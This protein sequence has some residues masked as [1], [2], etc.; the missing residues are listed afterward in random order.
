MD[1]NA[2]RRDRQ[3][4]F[5]TARHTQVRTE[6]SPALQDSPFDTPGRTESG[7]TSRQAAQ[8]RDE[9]H[10]IQLI[11]DQRVTRAAH[12]RQPLPAGRTERRDQHATL[13][14]LIE[15][16][17]RDGFPGRGQH[18]RIERRLARPAD[19][20]VVVARADVP[21]LHVAEAPTRL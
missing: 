11:A 9:T 19:V 2:S 15:Q 3:G 7:W 16:L 20:A 6:M 10:F 17:A 4:G 21:D 8:E 14:E 1:A 13:G 18:D 12:A 5:D